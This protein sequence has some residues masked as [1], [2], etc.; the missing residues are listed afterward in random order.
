MFRKPFQKPFRPRGTLK[1]HL[2]A[3][4]CAVPIVVLGSAEEL[5][6]LSCQAAKLLA[7]D[8][9]ELRGRPMP[10]LSE[11]GV[12]RFA[13]A[14]QIDGDWRRQLI[15]STRNGAAFEFW[16]KATAGGKEVGVLVPERSKPGS[17]SGAAPAHLSHELRTPLQG[18]LGLC[19]LLSGVELTEEAREY[20]ELI[21]S[22]ART[23]LSTVNEVLL[24][25]SL[26]R[27][28]YRVR[29]EP[30]DPHRTVLDI[31]RSVCT[32]AFLK[33]IDLFVDV[34]SPLPE[35]IVVDR[36]A[37][38][39]TVVNLVGNAV[40]F[41]DEG[42]VVVSLCYDRA[43]DALEVAVRDTGPG[44][45]TEELQRI[46]QPFEQGSSGTD[47]RHAGSGLGLSIVADLLKAMNGRLHVD[48]AP[49]CG[50]TFAFT[51][52]AVQGAAH[53]AAALP[54]LT[55][56]TVVVACSRRG[57]ESLLCERLATLG[58]SVVR[59][60]QCGDNGCFGVDLVGDTKGL[61]ALLTRRGTNSAALQD[62]RVVLLK[63]PGQAVPSLAG[64]T[65]PTVLTMPTSTLLVARALTDEAADAAETTTDLYGPSRNETILV[66]DDAPI[67]R[68][69]VQR[70]LERAG[71][72]V[73]TAS[74]G[75]EALQ[76]ASRERV[77]LILLDVC[78]PDMDGLTVIDI[79]RNVPSCPNRTTPVIAL[80]AD[81]SAEMR[82]AVWSRGVNYFLEKPV[83][84]S[85]LLAAVEAALGGTP[86][87]E[88]G[89]DTFLFVGASI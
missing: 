59:A 43:T 16:S 8:P 47:R 60:D 71:F 19:E 82:E 51:L 66:V 53:G 45:A 68:R 31:C 36:G 38:W 15:R 54:D 23:L 61:S 89:D 80:S 52:T 24:F 64:L 49:G 70:T 62:A 86:L 81:G 39:H 7:I 79:I 69:L 6:A 72:R 57:T 14:Q 78:M 77:D 3:I 85:E 17:G 33:D 1:K 26:Q 46:F 2:A 34:A 75:P 44:I 21:E 84:G 76:I 25:S 63:Y 28:K 50:S 55:G 4:D 27:G 32:N 65:N 37:F 42:Q 48:S 13:A 83:R 30:L 9:D 11:L 18:I 56:R 67:T 58:A 29:P 74:S 88:A 73:L 40:K 10:T 12:E 41:T 87:P 22:S 5:L 35:R 20:V